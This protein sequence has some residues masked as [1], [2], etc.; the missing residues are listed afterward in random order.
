MNITA[1]SI[2]AKVLILTDE[3]EIGQIWAYSLEQMNLS[4]T[5][6]EFKEV[7]CES[8]LA[9]P[10]DLLV[11]DDAKGDNH[12]ITMLH[13]CRAEAAMPILLLTVRTDENYILEA[14]QAGVDDCLPY[15]VSPRMFLAKMRALLRRS[16]LIPV[17]FAAKINAGG[18]CLD[19]SR[20]VLTGEKG[21]KHALTSL[22]A[23]LLFILM[24]YPGRAFSTEYLVEQV[25]GAFGGGDA[26]LLKNLVYR[27]RRKI[28]PTPNKPQVLLHETGEGYK[29][30]R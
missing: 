17:E 20:R 9:D 10:P 28:E 4:V 23:R 19:A 24:S 5:V 15:P 25:W 7:D 12:R 22:E 16:R 6:L 30:S 27:L 1:L 13:Q 18:F 26:A 11:L 21:E 29:F 14:Y 2:Q 8:I 3:K